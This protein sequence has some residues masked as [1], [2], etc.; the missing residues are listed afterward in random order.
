MLHSLIRVD[1]VFGTVLKLTRLDRGL[2]QEKLAIQANISRAYISQLERGLKDPSLFIIVK[3]SNA[4]KI[5]PSV[6]IYHVEHS[7]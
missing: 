3:L 6:F 1:E 4:L 2:S 7:L 5:K